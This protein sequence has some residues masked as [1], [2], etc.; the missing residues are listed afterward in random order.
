MC[1]STP[2]IPEPEPMPEAP[3]APPPQQEQPSATPPPELVGA[4]DKAPA[5]KKPTSKRSQMQQASK[6]TSALKIPLNT[7]GKKASG[8]NIPT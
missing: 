6:G 5:I 1:M 8:L 4:D 7:G 3:P 2:S